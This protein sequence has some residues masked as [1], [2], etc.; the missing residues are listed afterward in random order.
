MFLM[1]IPYQMHGVQVYSLSIIYFFILFT[2]N[3]QGKC[4]NFEELRMYQL[5]FLKNMLLV[6]KPG[7]L[8]PLTFTGVIWIPTSQHD[9]NVQ[10]KRS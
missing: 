10:G 3:L 9:M 5:F 7:R 6:P 2:W 4:F 8:Y 1:L